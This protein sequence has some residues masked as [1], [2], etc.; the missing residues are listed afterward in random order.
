MDHGIEP[1]DV[2]LV[3]APEFPPHAI[4]EMFHSPNS[5][6]L[7]KDTVYAEMSL[8]FGYYE[9]IALWWYSEDRKSNLA[10]ILTIPLDPNND[11]LP[12]SFELSKESPVFETNLFPS[13]NSVNRDAMIEGTVTFDGPFPNN[14]MAT[15]VA[16]FDFRP[17]KSL[18]YLIYLKSIDFSIDS[19]PYHFSLP[20]RNGVVSFISVF[21]LPERASLTDFRTIGVY[22]DPQNPNRPGVVYVPPGGKVTGIDIHASWETISEEN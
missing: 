11:F 13:W 2:Y 4:N 9:A 22:P 16:A 15:A 19:D 1:L 6:P 7:G 18:D 20:I 5:I 10:D 3:V 8:P 12:V 17:E 14:T 21:W